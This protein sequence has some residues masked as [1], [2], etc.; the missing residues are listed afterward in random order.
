VVVSARWRDSVVSE[1]ERERGGVRRA[2]VGKKKSRTVVV[3][4][5]GKGESFLTMQAFSGATVSS[6]EGTKCEG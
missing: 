4:A 1:R 5:N 2:A 6:A 3:P